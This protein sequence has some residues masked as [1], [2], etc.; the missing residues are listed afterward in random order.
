MTWT[1]FMD[2]YSGGGLKEKDY[3]YIFIEAPEAEAKI[4]FYNRFGHSPDRVS[5]T[6]CGDDYSV[7]ESPDLREATAYERGCESAY[8]RPD[9]TECP[10]AEAWKPGKGRTPGYS[11]GYVER[12]REESYAQPYQTLKAALKKGTFGSRG[13]FLLIYAKDIKPAERKGSVPESGYVWMGK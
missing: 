11:E 6:C 4:I 7:T 10:Q 8:F 12:K 2:M 9:G 1:Q 5:C 13:K 3:N